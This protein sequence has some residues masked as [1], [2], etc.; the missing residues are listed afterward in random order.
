M[1]DYTHEDHTKA[2]VL[3]AELKDYSGAGPSSGYDYGGNM[4]APR[5][6]LCLYKLSLLLTKIEDR[7]DKIEANLSLFFFD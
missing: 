2:H 6:E 5:E 7:L 4:S 3:K 1:R